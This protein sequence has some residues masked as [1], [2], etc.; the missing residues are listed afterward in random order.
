MESNKHLL[1]DEELTLI[2]VLRM[3]KIQ[4]TEVL[5]QA[6]YRAFENNSSDKERYTAAANEMYKYI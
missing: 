4:P 1:T 5:L 6:K 3:F 2:E